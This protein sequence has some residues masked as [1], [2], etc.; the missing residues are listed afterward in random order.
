LKNLPLKTST[1][2]SLVVGFFQGSDRLSQAPLQQAEFSVEN[3]LAYCSHPGIYVMPGNECET[4]K[5]ERQAGERA[6]RAKRR[7]KK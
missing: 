2:F 5:S 3:A 4:C 6:E 1:W 7:E